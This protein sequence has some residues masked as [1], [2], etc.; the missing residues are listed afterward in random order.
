MIGQ[1]AD[2]FRFED[3][4]GEIRMGFGGHF[5]AKTASGDRLELCYDPGDESPWRLLALGPKGDCL[6]V[7]AFATVD[8]GLDRMAEWADS[9]RHGPRKLYRVSFP[10]GHLHR[11]GNLRTEEVLAK[12]G[13]SL[14]ANARAYLVAMVDRDEEPVQVKLDFAERLG[15]LAPFLSSVDL[16]EN[17]GDQD[18]WCADVV[19]PANGFYRAPDLT[20][21][22]KDC[23]GS[24]G[25]EM[26]SEISIDEESEGKAEQTNAVILQFPKQ[27]A[28]RSA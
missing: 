27:P 28:Q 26:F 21:F 17:M 13:Y 11:P 9:P 4:P 16:V 3:M 10:G 20:Q 25:L 6:N 8:E 7:A 18:C 15:A 2:S 19:L 24:T 23:L 5:S 22:A 12:A 1:A 14:V